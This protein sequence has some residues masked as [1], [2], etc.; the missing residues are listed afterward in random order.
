MGAAF[1]HD[2]LRP[3]GLVPPPPSPFSKRWTEVK[4]FHPP[5]HPSPAVDAFA[6]YIVV[7]DSVAASVVVVAFVIASVAVAF[8][9]SV[10][11]L[12]FL[13]LQQFQFLSCTTSRRSW[14]RRCCC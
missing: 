11:L 13:L 2:P 3:T 12:L 4:A 5:P 9:L 1:V 10:V 8:L 6:V 14:G 7:V